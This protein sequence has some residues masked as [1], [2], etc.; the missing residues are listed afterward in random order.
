MSQT[1][2]KRI[3]QRVFHVV[4]LEYLRYAPGWPEGMDVWVVGGHQH[5]PVN[6]PHVVL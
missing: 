1:V 5:T 6:D 2:W 3:Y 4:H